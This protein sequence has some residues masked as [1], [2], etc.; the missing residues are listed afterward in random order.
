LLGDVKRGQGQQQD[1]ER[2]RIW[3][4]VF[5]EGCWQ[6]RGPSP[7]HSSHRHLCHCHQRV[8]RDPFVRR[9]SH[10]RS[11]DDERKGNVGAVMRLRLRKK[12]EPE[13]YFVATVWLSAR[14][15]E[16]GCKRERETSAFFFLSC[17]IEALRV[18]FWLII[19]LID[20]SSVGMPV[21]SVISVAPLEGPS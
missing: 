8:R 12:R 11:H 21:G 9:I 19:A 6:E 14:V 5:F 15:V 2:K 3:L 13:P 20:A 18:A 17:A 7:R 16:G 4:Q 10:E 1:G